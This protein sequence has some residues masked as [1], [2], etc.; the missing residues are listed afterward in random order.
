MQLK[1]AATLLLFWA[2]CLTGP[3]QAQGAPKPAGPSSPDLSEMRTVIA[4]CLARHWRSPA[5]APFVRV[6]LRW[7]LKKDGMLL[8]PPE[9]VGAGMTPQIAPSAAR[10]IAAVRACQPFKLPPERYDAWKT[11]TW[12]FDPGGR[13]N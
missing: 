9:L 11:I 7:H 12:E 3:A 10:A 6:T 8:K 4:S 1:V 13:S 5:N 2:T